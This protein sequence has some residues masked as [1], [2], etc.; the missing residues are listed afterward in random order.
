MERNKELWYNRTLLNI[1]VNTQ[2][3]CRRTSELFRH[4]FKWHHNNNVCW[5]W[6]LSFPG[7]RLFFL[8]KTVTKLYTVY[9]TLNFRIC[10]CVTTKFQ[11][12]YFIKLICGWSWNCGIFFLK[13]TQEFAKKLS[14]R[15]LNEKRV[16]CNEMIGTTRKLLGR[17]LYFLNRFSVVYFYVTI[18]MVT[19]NLALLFSHI[20]ILNILVSLILVRTCC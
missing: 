7:T 11:V 13:I 14:L 16:F 12:N 9:A 1:S 2:F 19:Y 18:K 10:Y 4:Y 6:I 3:S 5:Q 15:H 17:I 8:K 20:N